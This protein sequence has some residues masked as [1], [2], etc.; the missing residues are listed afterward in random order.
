MREEVI[1]VVTPKRVGVRVRVRVRVRSLHRVTLCHALGDQL[2]HA[3]E[4][5]AT[6]LG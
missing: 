3:E 4:L 1:Q 5:G 2:R 6:H